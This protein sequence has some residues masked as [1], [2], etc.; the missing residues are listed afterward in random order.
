M[1]RSFTWMSS[2]L[3]K[4]LITVTTGQAVEVFDRLFC[5]LYA[6][7]SSVD[8]RPVAKEPEPELEPLSLPVPA[9]APS[10]AMA[11]KL[12]SPKYAMLALSS[13]VRSADPVEPPSPQN[14]KKDTKKGRRKAAPVQE[15]RS[16]LAKHALLMSL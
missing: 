13:P 9:A 8:L 11:R 12:Y 10:A 4:N 14:S 2:R 7:S 16:C 5:V 1:S 15:D 6:T 3:D